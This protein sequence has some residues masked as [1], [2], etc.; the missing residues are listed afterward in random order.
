MLNYYEILNVPPNAAEEDIRK[1]YRE[2]ARMAS[3]RIGDPG[4]I[5]IEGHSIRD[6]REAWLVLGDHRARKEYHLNSDI[7]AWIIASGFD[8]Q[9]ALKA[10]ESRTLTKSEKAAKKAF[11]EAREAFQAERFNDALRPL[12]EAIKLDH[13][14]DLYQRNLG[15]T[16]LKTG[17][18]QMAC[19]AF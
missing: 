12:L 3:L 18:P 7:D 8:Q 2:L 17:M 13:N 10:C 4:P 16:Y 11:H 1:A 6:I 15:L 5:D 14:N 19:T 9:K